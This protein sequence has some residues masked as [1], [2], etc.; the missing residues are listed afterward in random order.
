MGDVDNRDTKIL[1]NLLDFK[2]HALPE[3]GVQVAEGLIQQQ[4]LGLRHQGAAQGHPLLLPARKLAGDALGVLAQVHRLQNPFHLLLD[5][6][7]IQLFNLQGIG[8]IVKDG[9]MGPDGVG[10]EDHANIPLF[11]GNKGLFGA[12]HSAINA[13]F[14]GGGLFKPGNHPQH[15]GLAAA[16]GTQQGDK[17]FILENLVELLQHHNVAEGLCHLLDGDGRHS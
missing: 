1:L 5:D 15:G 11:R 6:G 8:H 16:G 10:L 3:L 2:A 7:L 13:D 9:H 14:A 4:Q 12:D 17:F